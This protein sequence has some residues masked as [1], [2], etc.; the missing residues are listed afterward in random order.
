MDHD[1]GGAKE[2][3]RSQEKLILALMGKMGIGKVR[4]IAVLFTLVSYLFSLSRFF[5]TR[6]TFDSIKDVF[7]SVFLNPSL[8]ELHSSVS[9]KR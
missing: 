6:N 2:K 8:Q 5:F 7:P 4:V 9:P 1:E 3:K